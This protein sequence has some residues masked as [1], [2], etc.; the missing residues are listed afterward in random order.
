MSDSDDTDILLLIPPDFFVAETN[1]NESFNYDRIDANNILQPI[2]TTPKRGASQNILMNGKSTEMDRK[3][4]RISP[5]SSGSLKKQSASGELNNCQTR[6]RSVCA[7]QRLS[8]ATAT[9]T[10]MKS[11]D[12]NYLK[13]IDSYLAGYTS[14]G[15]KIRD[16]NAI[17]ASNGITPLSFSDGKRRYGQSTVTNGIPST[18]SNT[19]A[20]CGQIS[21]GAR[22]IN[23]NDDV[24]RTLDGG[25]MSD[26]SFALQQQNGNH[27]HE[28]L[29]SLNEVWD[30][31]PSTARLD[32]EEEQLR[33]RQ[34]E[35][36][37]ESMQHQVKEY[38]EKISAAIKMDQ[39]K[40]EALAKLHD[41]N[42]K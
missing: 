18:P 37:L 16:V 7:S 10:P 41:T 14:S 15:T 36:Q 40:N 25:R 4:H 3:V 30:A 21:A 35:R 6:D 29:V 13:E 22:H 24:T 28:P 12:D 23:T 26:W 33:R 1:A 8:E 9:R 17:L 19:N 27:N 31:D 5:S 42:S 34:C 20:R 11:N 2:I 38:Q 32:I 39:A